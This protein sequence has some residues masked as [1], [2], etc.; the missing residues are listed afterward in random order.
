MN[1]KTFKVLNPSCNCNPNIFH[2][3]PKPSFVIKHLLLIKLL[4]KDKAKWRNVWPGES[5]I[6]KPFTPKLRVSLGP[7]S[8]SSLGQWPG[9]DYEFN[10]GQS[11]FPVISNELSF[12]F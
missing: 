12:G 2:S 5:R 4:R 9:Q 11:K 8:G 6:W 3:K 7:D 1:Q 10:Q